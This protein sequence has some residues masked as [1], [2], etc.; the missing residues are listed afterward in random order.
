LNRFQYHV[1]LST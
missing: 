1:W